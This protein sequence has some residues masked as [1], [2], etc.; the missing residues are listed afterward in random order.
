VESLKINPNLTK[1]F[2]R[3]ALSCFYKGNY[4]EALEYIDNCKES[5]NEPELV[6]LRSAIEAKK[7]EYLFNLESIN[8]Q[9]RNR[10]SLFPEIFKVF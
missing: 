8:F 3:A 6:N 10:L 1:G 7:N 5:S 4:K 2:Y 9:L